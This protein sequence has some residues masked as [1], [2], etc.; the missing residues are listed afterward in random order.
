MLPELSVP[1]NVVADGFWDSISYKV[2]E[3]VPPLSIGTDSNLAYLAG[4]VLGDGT[5]SV[6]YCAV[7][8][9]NVSKTDQMGVPYKQWQEIL[10]DACRKAGCDPVAR[11]ESV[12]L[13]SRHVIRFLAAL[14]LYDL[15]E[16]TNGSRRLR[17]PDWVW[18]A[19]SLGLFP[20]LGGLFDTDGTV[21]SRD[22]NLSVTTKDP[23]FAGHIAAALQALGMQVSVDASWN[24]TYQKWYFRVKVFR[25]DSVQFIPYMKHPGKIARLKAEGRVAKPE[26]GRRKPNEVLLVLDAG[27]QECV[28]LHVGSETHLY[29]ANGF[30]SHNSCNF[31][32]CYGGGGSA[33]QRAVGVDKNEGW[34]IKNQFDKTYTGLEHWWKLT[35]KFAKQ[36]AFVRTAF[37]RKYPLPDIN[38]TDGF[39]ASK[40]ER[41]ATNGPVQ[42]SSADITKTAMAF[43]YRECKNRGWLDKCQMI[44]TMHD[45]LV[46][47][48][49]GDILEEAIH[50]LVPIM[51]RN[52][53]ILA[54]KW[55][56]P[57][58]CDV[59][60]GDHWAVPWDLNAMRYKE[61]RYEGNKK[62]K[63]PSKPKPE[64]FE[65]PVEYEKAKSLFP[66]KLA[67]W[68]AIPHTFPEVLRPLFKVKTPVSLPMIAE[69]GLPQP[70]EEDQVTLAQPEQEEPV[71]V[72]E[73]APETPEPPPSLG[74][75]GASLGT[76]T[77]VS[78]APKISEGV[79][80]FQ[81]TKPLTLGVLERIAD[82][83]VKCDKKGRAR[84]KLLDMRGGDVP[85][86]RIFPEPIMVNPSEF[87]F[88]AGSADV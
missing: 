29:W 85:L 27:E 81:L 5:K 18:S 43:I 60:I 51:T 32:M 65:D 26:C 33:A 13:G 41:N 77:M 87:Y 71:Q 24:K 70:G 47:E 80:E 73:T 86:D 31:A 9:G 62:L 56:V 46:F 12:Y 79:Y 53:Y 68:K 38:S 84:L 15:T 61:V 21:S 20:F 2:F 54:M 59:E 63:E 64:D 58:T 25:E 72:E 88:L 34:R 4:L 22:K 78:N 52:Q 8:H 55:P 83:I 36:H 28:D 14:Q 40:A 23:V 44:I 76:P 3:G 67:K 66:E 17:I 50:V 69:E 7:T 11:K 48:I 19:G 42:G 37:N 82:V 30:S 6:S 16:G 49:D 1:T 35:K 45:E 39:W 74:S 10:M 75:I 57:L